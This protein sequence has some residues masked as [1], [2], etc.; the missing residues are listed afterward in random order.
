MG[1]FFRGI[2]QYGNGVGRGIIDRGG[3]MTEWE[4]YERLMNPRYEKENQKLSLNN[5]ENDLIV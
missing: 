1:I 3:D 2:L 4:L 5:R